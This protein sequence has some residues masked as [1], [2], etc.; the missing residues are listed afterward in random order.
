MNIAPRP[1]PARKRSPRGGKPALRSGRT[2]R[3]KGVVL[4]AVLVVVVILTLA[5][6]QFNDLMLAEYRSAES[7]RRS[8]QAQALAASGIHYAAATLSN[9]DALTNVL[10]GNPYDNA[11]FQ[12]VIVRAD[13]TPRRQGRFTLIAPLDPD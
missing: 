2:P 13:D 5:A 7:Y 10:A 11:A 8:V 6:Y 9:P 12:G 4:L 1:L 3:R